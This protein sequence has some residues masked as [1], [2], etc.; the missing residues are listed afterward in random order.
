MKQKILMFLLVITFIAGV[1]LHFF[2]LVQSGWTFD[3][4]FKYKIFY[5]F[6]S[7]ELRIRI[8]WVLSY[9]M[10][11]GSVLLVQFKLR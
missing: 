7:A 10:M 8:L 6:L 4:F 9:F 1:I 11:F 2:C 5:L 3:I